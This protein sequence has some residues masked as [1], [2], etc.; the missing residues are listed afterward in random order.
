MPQTT[1]QW[2]YFQGRNARFSEGFVMDW[3]E[4]FVKGE[5]VSNGGQRS[6]PGCAADTY[7]CRDLIA[8]PRLFVGC[9]RSYFVGMV[10]TARGVRCI[11]LDRSIVPFTTVVTQRTL[12]RCFCLTSSDRSQLLF[13]T[14]SNR[15]SKVT[16][17]SLRSE[18]F[19]KKKYILVQEELKDLASNRIASFVVQQTW[20]YVKKSNSI[21]YRKYS[22]KLLQKFTEIGWYSRTQILFLTDN[23]EV[24]R[25]IPQIESNSLFDN[26]LEPKLKNSFSWIYR[27]MV[28]H[29]HKREEIFWIHAK[30]IRK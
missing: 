24:E 28:K 29:C 15:L 22:W 3:V 9:I 1:F 30:N 6:A 16:S 8:L 25:K 19:S 14:V 26:E 27:N 4:C 2:E 17:D 20:T 7:I 12:A 5:E 23:T 18:S 11:D 10:V 13:S 21:D